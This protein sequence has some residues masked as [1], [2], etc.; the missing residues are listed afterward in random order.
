MILNKK[1]H[2][3]IRATVMMLVFVVA[4]STIVCTDV[5]AKSK[6][7]VVRRALLVAETSSPQILTDNTNA[8]RTMLLKQNFSGKK[9][10]IKVYNNKSKKQITKK[11]KST[12]KKTKKNDVSYLYLAAHGSKTGKIWLG[13]NGNTFFTPAEL[14]KVCDKYIKGTVVILMSSCY[15]GNFV[16]DSFISEFVSA[17]SGKKSVKKAKAQAKKK[18]RI[19]C[20]A[21]NNE[22][23]Y[24]YGISWAT[25]FWAKAGGWD[26]I[27]NT[28]TT[29]M[30][31]A[32]IDKKVTL[33]ELYQYSRNEILKRC[34]EKEADGFDIH[35][36]H[37][38][39]YPANSNFVVFGSY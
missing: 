34:A 37:V 10:S 2:G 39:C 4:V 7:K 5:S 20:S 9:I 8:I 32:N 15:S 14:R 11:I 13:K 16:G 38:M 36:Q 21:A 28:N 30:A 23:S 18:Y 25:E 19:L 31:D 12:F 24:T 3:I 6:K 33:N 17:K 1:R 27:K 29:L 26:P 35:T 22:V